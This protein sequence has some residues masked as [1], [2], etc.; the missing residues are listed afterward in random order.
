MTV[1]NYENTDGHCC[2]T[3]RCDEIKRTTNRQHGFIQFYMPIITVDF[4]VMA[5]RLTYADAID[6]LT[7]T[8]RQFM[9]K[10]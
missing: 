4:H 10:L 1:E 9:N 5:I 8:A 3:G 6:A 2:F 7:D